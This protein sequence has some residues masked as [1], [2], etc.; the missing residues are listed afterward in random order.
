MGSSLW[1]FDNRYLREKFYFIK[2]NTQKAH[3]SRILGIGTDIDGTNTEFLGIFYRDSI[4][5]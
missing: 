4:L 5:Y 3:D 2:H 1:I